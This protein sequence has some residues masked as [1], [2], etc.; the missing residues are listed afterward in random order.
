MATVNETI[1]IEDHGDGTIS[2]FTADGHGIRAE[3][4][5]FLDGPEDSLSRIK[6][7]VRNFR[8]SVDLSGKDSTE[9]AVLATESKAWTGK[10]VK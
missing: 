2:V 10:V 5:F 1:E 6:H 8:A 4:A 3:L 7:L 9:A